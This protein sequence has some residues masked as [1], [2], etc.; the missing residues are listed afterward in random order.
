LLV[1]PILLPLALGAAMLFLG[2]KRRRLEATLAIGGALALIVNGLAL[3]AMTDDP[4]GGTIGTA[5]RLGNWPAMFGIVLVA[6][7]LSSLMVL[8]ASG[9][10][11]V[12]AVFALSRCSRLGPYYFALSQFLLMGLNGSFLT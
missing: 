2:P 5:Y 4:S 6:D 8:L 7:R 3:V 12:N 11:L 1:T 9:L 10:G